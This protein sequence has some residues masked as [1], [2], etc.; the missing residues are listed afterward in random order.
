RR[1]PAWARC[2]PPHERTRREHRRAPSVPYVR[3]TPA[4]PR[5]GVCSK[6][7]RWS[8]ASLGLENLNFL[9]RLC[10]VGL[11]SRGARERDCELGICFAPREHVLCAMVLV[12][13]DEREGLRPLLLGE[14]QVQRRRGN[15]LRTSLLGTADRAFGGSHPSFRSRRTT[16]REQEGRHER[17]QDHRTGSCHWRF[18]TVTG[19]RCAGRATTKSQNVAIRQ[20]IDR[21]IG[22]RCVASARARL[23]PELVTRSW[24][25]V[26][27]L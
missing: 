12:V 27:H 14:P 13:L 22:A 23:L 2:S 19:N 18:L 6:I 15:A 3:C 21:A 10:C 4:T 11:G 7:L 25:C 26:G 20:A 8:L 24:S 9:G 17:A 16:A 1:V 5:A